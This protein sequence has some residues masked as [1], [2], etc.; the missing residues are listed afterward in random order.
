VKVNEVS[1]NIDSL[2]TT[3]VD[4]KV[5]SIIFSE[6]LILERIEIFPDKTDPK[7]VDK[8]YEL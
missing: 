4:A 8:I 2:T 6:V 1:L 7:L 5:A 3:K